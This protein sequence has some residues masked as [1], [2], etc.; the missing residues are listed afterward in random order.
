M[1]PGEGGMVGQ[2]LIGTEFFGEVE[3]AVNMEG[4]W[5]VVTAVQHFECV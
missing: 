4:G 3:K 2:C 1:A 5:K